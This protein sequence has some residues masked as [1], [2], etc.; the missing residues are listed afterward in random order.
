MTTYVLNGHGIHFFFSLN[1]FQSWGSLP[2]L[3]FFPVS[4]PPWI[5]FSGLILLHLLDPFPALIDYPSCFATLWTSFLIFLS[6]APHKLEGGRCNGECTAHATKTGTSTPTWLT[7]AERTKPPIGEIFYLNFFFLFASTSR[8][9]VTSESLV[10]ICLF[11]QTN[12]AQL[13]N[14]QIYW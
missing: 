12:Q 8:V 11:H 5:F 7:C 14:K 6:D 13:Q 9:V 3:F 10:K 4:S 2:F 1:I